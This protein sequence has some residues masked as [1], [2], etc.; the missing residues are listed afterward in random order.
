MGFFPRKL[1]LRRW[2]R[3]PEPARSATWVR[4]LSPQQRSLLS[5][6]LRKLLESKKALEAL[7]PTHERRSLP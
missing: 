1:G 5:L 4:G 6:N 7:A 3:S 2:R